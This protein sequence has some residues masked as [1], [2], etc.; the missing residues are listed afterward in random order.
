MKKVLFVATVVKK[1][2]NQFHLPYLKWF[3][4]QGFEVHVFAKNDYDNVDDCVIPFCDKFFDSG[5]SRKPLST[6]NIKSYLELKKLIDSN[7]Y[8]LIHCHTPVGG[9]LTRLAARKARKNGTKVL[10]T[11]HGFHF[12]KGAPLQNWLIYYPIERVLAHFTDAIIT[13]NNE[14]YERAQKFKCVV[15]FTHGIGVQ[16]VNSKSTDLNDLKTHLGIKNEDIVLIS[17]G[18]LNNNKNHESVIKALSKIRNK[19]IKYLICGDGNKR[20]YLKKLICK[21]NLQDNVFLLG[22]QKNVFN[23]L[24]ISDLFL[25]PSIR[26]GLSVS[27]LEAMSVG[28]FVSCSK[29]R[30]NRDL[31]VEGE[32][33]NFFNPNDIRSIKYQISNSLTHAKKNFKDYNSLIINQYS[34]DNVLIETVS[35]YKVFL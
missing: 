34:I 24:S 17:I 18:E 9:M 31:V 15:Y 25:F 4:G 14:D 27:L 6:K 29:I 30:G 13:I 12:Y 32:N 26:E 33:G 21:L 8:T 10:Y 7:Q 35:I 16:I 22:Y 1:H 2:I 19:H 23:Y 3:H 28:L 5:I 20:E 11:A